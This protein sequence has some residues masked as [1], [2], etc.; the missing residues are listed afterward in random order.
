VE[1][2]DVD[3]GDC[4]Y[5]GTGVVVNRT[6]NRDLNAE[7][8]KSLTAGFVFSPSAHFQFTVDYFRVTLDNQVDDLSIDTLAR[9]EA[10]CRLGTSSSLTP[11]SPTCVD[12]FS[13][14]TRFTTGAL[15]GQIASVRV[16]PINIARERTSG[17]DFSFRGSLPT[18][19]GRFTLNLSHSH[20]LD[21]TFIQYPGDPAV[22]KMAVDSGYYLP[23]DKSNGSITWET[24]ALQFT[25]SGTRLGKLPNYDEDAFIKASYLFNATLQADMTDRLRA[26]LTIRNLLDT[27][28]VKDPTWSGYPYYNASWFDSTGRSVFMQLT[29][30]IGGS[31][32]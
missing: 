32:L 13:R 21:H 23:R 28:P 10:D 27:M 3:V 16:N 12:A 4:S 25:V 5:S 18:P 15:A 31:P 11:T 2:P 19:I 8:G 20:V 22:D 9:T 30:K 17:L 7:T 24:D 14:I 26:S 29:Y 6:G 1:E